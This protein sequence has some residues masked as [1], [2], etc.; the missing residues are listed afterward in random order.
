LLRGEP[1]VANMAAGRE[2]AETVIYS[3]MEALL[4]KTG[5][6][7]KAIDFL[8]IN[9]SLFNPTPSLCCM[10]ER[11]FGLRMDVRSFNLSGM[12]CS[13]GLIAVDLAK[14]LLQSRPNSTAVVVST[15]IIAT[16]LYTGSERSM[17]VQNTLFRS[18][19]SAVLLSNKPTDRFRAK[20]MLLNTVRTTESSQEAYDAV[21]ECEDAAGKRG[22]RLS[23]D[24]TTVAG[25]AL[26]DNFT[27]LGPQ[28]LPIREQ[29]KVIYTVVARKVCSLLR[30]RLEA[31]GKKEW[32][33]AI[34]TP[35]PYVPDFKKGVQHFCI[36][37]GGR[38]VIDGIE[39]NL[40]LLPRHTAPSRATLS[41]FGNTSSSSIWYE[42]AF[43]EQESDEWKAPDAG[44]PV[45]QGERV[46]Q[47]AFGSGF[48]CNSAVWLRLRR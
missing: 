35:V 4:K 9:C 13:A 30:K 28:V 24:I 37:A 19:G 26:K 8:V 2:E 16:A 38:G 22:V 33:A 6:H 20:Y 25:R 40:S 23:K 42:L 3:T 48:R 7:P 46:L 45:K 15:E 27:M 43:V 11:K 29:A 14:S 12:G 32:A 17:L 39:K 41:R 18:G 47:I 34:P 21:Y 5:T 31:A 1:L 44:P 10:V 36:H